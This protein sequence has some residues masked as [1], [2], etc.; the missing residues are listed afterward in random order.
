MISAHVLTLLAL[1]LSSG[2]FTTTAPNASS[3]S[4]S[5]GTLSRSAECAVS[6][7]ASRR[8]LSPASCCAENCN[9]PKK[10][11]IRQYPVTPPKDR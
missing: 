5:V 11:H 1:S 7:T 6:K 10:P 4:A 8:A 9:P 2:V 3:T